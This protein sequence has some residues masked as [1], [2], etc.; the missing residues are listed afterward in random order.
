MQRNG[1]DSARIATRFLH[2]G[3]RELEWV[4]SFT[5][6]TAR[7]KEILTLCH[8][9]HGESIAVGCNTRLTEMFDHNTIISTYN[10]VLASMSVV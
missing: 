8:V 7:C 9:G 4:I 1:H 6:F 3:H 10:A 2:R 5:R